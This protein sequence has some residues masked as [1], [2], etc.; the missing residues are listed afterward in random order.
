MG[1]GLLQLVANGAQDVY[2][3]GNPQITFWKVVYRRHT[4]FST[5]V[6]E[7]FIHG[8]STL[9]S[10][11]KSGEAII[12]RNGD[13]LRKIYISSDTDGIIMGD[14]IIN[15]VRVLIGG[16]KIDEHTCEWMQIWNELTCP[17]T[18]SVG[19]KSLQGCI[20]SSG[21]TGVNEV[22]IPLLFWFCRNAGLALPLVA[23]QYHEVKLVFD[24][25]TSTEVG[26]A[27][28]VKLWCEYIYLDTDERRRFAQMPHEYLIEQ[29]QYKEEGTSKLSYKFAFNHPVK[30][31]FWTS[32]NSITTESATI[33]LNGRDRFKSQKKEYFQIHQPYDYHTSIPRQNLPVG[34]NR[35]IT[36][37]ATIQKTTATDITDNTKCKISI[38]ADGL[39]GTILFRNDVDGML[40]D[41][42]DKLIIYDADHTDHTT[43][44]R[45]IEREAVNVPVDANTGIRYS[46]SMV[47]TGRNTGVMDVPHNDDTLQLEVVKEDGFVLQRARTS[48]MIRNINCYS[49]ALEPEE[50]QPTGTCNFSRIDQS[51]L[52]FSSAVTIQ[53]IYALNYNIF[54][55]ISGM[56][57]LAYSN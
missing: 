3:T 1:G 11:T 25:G 18:K 17:E 43:V 49:F 21:T 51:T 53:N 52:N 12:A 4:N 47:F 36:L 14:K 16:E 32:E 54:R 2:I 33:K 35:P 46:F 39:S 38:D 55:V 5:E 30:E 6:I 22:H 27:A 28:E 8:T 45:I 56:G 26:A 20:G 9:E 50:Y 7:Q 29:V 40:V 31:L 34:L 19:L 13:L 10:S 24:W 42:G 57:G 37:T 41:V 44:V 23:L 48:S 15:K